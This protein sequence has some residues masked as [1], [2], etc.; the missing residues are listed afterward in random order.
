MKGRTGSFAGPAV[1]AQSGSLFESV[2]LQ[3]GTLRGQTSLADG[4][5]GYSLR[6]N[7]RHPLDGYWFGEAGLSLGFIS[8]ARYRTR[9]LPVEYRFNYRL[10]GFGIDDLELFSRSGS[11]YLFTGGGFLYHK[12]V[13]VPAPEDPFTDGMGDVLPVSS[14]WSFGSGLDPYIPVGAGMD[15]QLDPSTSLNLQFSYNQSLHFLSLHGDGF[16]QGYWGLTVGLNFGTDRKPVR[17]QPPVGLQ[18]PLRKPVAFR[19]LPQAEPVQIDLDP[20]ELE[21]ALLTGAIMADINRTVLYFDVLSAEIRPEDEQVLDRIA[22]VLKHFDD[23]TL[24]VSGHADSTG[25]NPVNEMIS[26]SRARAVWLELVDRGVDPGQI[27]LSAYA[28]RQPLSVNRLPEYWFTRYRDRRVNFQTEQRA[29]QSV[30]GTA[31]KA[32]PVVAEFEEFEYGEPLLNLR[33]LTFTHTMLGLDKHSQENLQMVSGLL[34]STPEMNLL[35]FSEAEADTGP[36]FGLALSKARADLIRAELVLTGI[37]AGRL[38][39]VSRGSDDGNALF[40]LFK[41][42]LSGPHQHNLVIPV[43]VDTFRGEVAGSGDGDEVKGENSD[44]ASASTAGGEQ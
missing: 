18:P 20:A 39:V 23:Y 37:E 8:G 21:P 17:A 16:R 24:S 11:P 15:F 5:P 44:T 4:L 27:E 32:I 36:E 34:H 10:S 33:D 9:L 43:E 38:K 28:D 13:E 29:F 22:R 35:I 26:E 6:V 42:Y 2:G 31:E 3:F 7:A 14:L 19:H 12:P 41:P 1:E 40:K 30:Y 25:L